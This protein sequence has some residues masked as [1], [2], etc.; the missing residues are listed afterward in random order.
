M[1]LEEIVPTLLAGAKL[2][3]RDDAAMAS[4]QAFVDGVAAEKITVLNLPTGFWQVLLAALEAGTAKLPPEV[5]L[6]IVGGERM[7]PD[8]WARWH[9]LTGQAVMGL[10]RLM[11]AYGPTEATITCTVYEQIGATAKVGM[12][13]SWGGQVPVGRSF[14]HALTY[15]RAPDG[16]LAPMGARA[17]LWVGGDA[18]ALG[19]LNQPQLTAERFVA[20]PYGPGR[21]YRSGDVAHWADGSDAGGS[22]AG[23]Q[24]VIAGRSDRQIK[25]RGFRIEP[26]EVEGV[27]ERMPGVAQA[28]VGVGD[29]GL[30]GWLRPSDAGAVPDVAAVEALLAQALPKSHRPEVLFVTDW[31]Q[32]PSGKTDERRLPAPVRAVVQEADAG[33][34]DPQVTKIAELFATVLGGGLPPVGASFF[35]LGGHSL[36]L[37]T[38]IGQIETTFGVRLAVAQVHR[39][40][41]PLGLS[42]L[43]A[44][45]EGRAVPALNLAE[46]V[47]PIQ[48]LGA[49]IPIY[50]VPVLGINGSFLRPLADAMGPDLEALAR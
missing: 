3:L 38:L 28:H 35:D 45:Q 5:R 36:Q 33:K 14:G 49:G 8:A 24:L 12:P 18:V 32:T 46:C 47:M 17:E 34:V 10:P 9:V 44:A 42:A 39:A 11:N 22:D 29:Q 19:Y 27:L 4:P 30:V 13:K 16:S 20:N 37:L 48:P 41:T 43:I 23:P 15:L 40:P 2:V 50:G 6:V 7:P 26:A 31:P 1:A 25:L 21:M